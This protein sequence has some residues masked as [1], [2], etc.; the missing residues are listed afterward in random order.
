MGLRHAPLR[1]SS[2]P[3]GDADL[4]YAALEYQS[5]LQ[6]A[7]FIEDLINT[8]LDPDRHENGSSG[9][10]IFHRDIEPVFVNIDTEYA[11]LPTHPLAEIKFKS[12]WFESLPPPNFE[13][14]RLLYEPVAN[15]IETDNQLF[16]RD[17]VTDT[18]HSANFIGYLATTHPGNLD[19]S[20]R[21][22]VAIL[23]GEAEWRG[24]EVSWVTKS[25]SFEEVRAEW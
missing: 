1:A 15:A 20:T 2:T 22:M 5:P 19:A 23:T 17:T 4:V 18:I 11:S 12:L 10:Y 25:E 3:I 14:S 16:G 24:E 9:D 6:A 13:H 8:T 21:D 7:V